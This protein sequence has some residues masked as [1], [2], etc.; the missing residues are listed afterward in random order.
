MTNLR[1]EMERLVECLRAAGW[2]DPVIVAVAVIERGERIY[3][4]GDPLAFLLT[5]AALMRAELDKGTE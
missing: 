2:D 4:G 3:N 1:D 5:I